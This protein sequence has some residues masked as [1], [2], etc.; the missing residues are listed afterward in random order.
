MLQVLLLWELYRAGSKAEELNSLANHHFNLNIL[1]LDVTDESQYP[2]FIHEV[3]GILDGDGLNLLINNAGITFRGSFDSITSQ[4]M[5]DVYK[6]NVVAPLMLSK[7]CHGLLKKAYVSAA[8]P[9]GPSKA[10]V[11]HISSDLGSIERNGLGN[12]VGG[13]YAYRP[14]KTALNMVT[15]SMSIDLKPDGKFTLH[16]IMCTE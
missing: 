6:T 5:M 1:H 13:L 16:H 3:G 14:S 12:L 8:G 15:K 7:A 9:M 11:V 2:S 10:T 4:G